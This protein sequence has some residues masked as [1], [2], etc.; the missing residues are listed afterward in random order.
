MKNVLKSQLPNI[1]KINSIP[2]ALSGIPAIKEALTQKK[3]GII[4][5]YDDVAEIKNEEESSF[6]SFGKLL[7]KGNFLNKKPEE[8]KGSVVPKE[9]L[10]ASMVIAESHAGG[11]QTT[12]FRVEKEIEYVDNT[13]EKPHIIKAQWMFVDR[14]KGE[15][16]IGKALQPLAEIYNDF[17][18][19]VTNVEKARDVIEKEIIKGKTLLTVVCFGGKS[20]EKYVMLDYDFVLDSMKPKRLIVDFI[21]QEILTYGNGSKILQKGDLDFG[22]EVMFQKDVDNVI[23][24][25]GS[26]AKNGLTSVKNA[27]FGMKK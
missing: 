16:I 6:G 10:R 7:G 13:I 24:N 9:L 20:Y 2:S 23:R 22:N 11:V 12:N 5:K 25:I 21:F 4:L 18:D 8:K 27:V 15:G 17:M 1:P 26:S 14:P 19:N 3:F